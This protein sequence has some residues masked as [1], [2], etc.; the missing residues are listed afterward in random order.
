MR[1]FF[2]RL[3]HR[4]G[5]VDSLLCLGLDPHPALLAESSA[6]AARDFC[7]ELMAQTAEFACAIKPNSAFFEA[8]GEQGWVALRDVIEEVPVGLPVILDAKRGDIASSAEA[9]ARAAFD[10]LGADAITVSPYLGGDA[11]Q[12]FL[13]RTG[14]GI[15]L[16][17]KTSNPGADDL[18]GLT[19][20]ATGEPLYVHLARQVES[21]GPA[22]AIGLVV[23]ATD[24]EAIAAV[25]AAAPQVW[26]LAPGV[27]PQGGN[28]EA[29]LQAGLRPDGLGMILPVSRAIAAAE[30]P[31]EQARSLR[32]AINA[33]RS[34]Y[35]PAQATVLSP[36]LGSLADALLEAGCVCFGSFTLKSGQKSPIYFDLR[37]LSSQPHL[38]ARVAAAYGRMLQ[39]LT[40][41]CLAAIPY[42]ALPI[43][44]AISLQMGCPMIYPR[45]DVKK[46]GRRAQVE[47]AFTAGER[48]VVVDDLVTTGGSKFEAIARL[49]EA[50]LEVKDVA[51]LIDRQGG[52][53]QE[54]QQAGYRLHA[55][56]TLSQ[57]LDHWEARKSVE[58]GTLAEVRKYLSR[59]GA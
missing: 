3:A 17:C 37:V 27:G 7:L 20:G 14:T 19:V 28:L 51:V 31:Y 48:A 6:A 29:A 36:E 1:D 34:A 49:K 55:V 33:V 30:R 13:Q 23:G 26:I 10:I 4:V 57:L 46:H 52:A 9:Y 53:K 5:E 59:R 11:L 15:F 12:P 44:T 35:R 50:G 18:Q 38:L 21:W 24:P 32:D 16:L 39:G 2:T 41:D 58:Q 47:G 25:R 45:L 43:G 56:F 22:D 54:L 8:Y 42:A 40:F